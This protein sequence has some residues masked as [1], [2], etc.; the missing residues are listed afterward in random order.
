MLWELFHTVILL[1]IENLKTHDIIYMNWQTGDDDLGENLNSDLFLNPIF[2][3]GYSHY[4]LSY[5][6]A[7]GAGYCTLSNLF[8]IAKSSICLII[9]EFA[10]LCA[11]SSSV[12]IGIS[13][14]DN[15]QEDKKLNKFQYLF[16]GKS[17]SKKSG[18]CQ[19]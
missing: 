3:Y 12:F 7:T 13:Q 17:H 4:I 14:E 10:G 8:G 16:K 1:N 18:L 11:M 2:Y 19:L 15:I 9:Q 5:Q 6:L